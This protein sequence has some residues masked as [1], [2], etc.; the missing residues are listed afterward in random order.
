MDIDTAT[1]LFGFDPR[2]IGLRH[3]S[4]RIVEDPWEGIPGDL[5]VVTRDGDIPDKEAFRKPNFR[6]SRWGYEDHTYRY[7]YFAPL[8]LVVDMAWLY[9][10]PIQ[11]PS[12]MSATQCNP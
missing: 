9:P 7:Y 6:S 10:K 3:R 8:L 4:W 5:C 2:E 12:L 11:S 1:R